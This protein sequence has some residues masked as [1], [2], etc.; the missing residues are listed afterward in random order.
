MQAEDKEILRALLSE[1]RVLSLGVVVD[2]EPHVGLLPFIVDPDLQSAFVH[3]SDLARHSRG[4]VQGA[5][6]RVL[7]HEAD[8]PEGDPLQV[9][10]VTISGTVDQ[11]ARTDGEYPRLRRAYIDRFPTSERTFLLGDFYLY[12]LNFERGRLVAGFARAVNLRPESFAG[13]RQT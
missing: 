9:A 2:G 12:R 7:I 10:R 8:D 11:L 5:A 6:F 1:S 13:L 3:A 4:L